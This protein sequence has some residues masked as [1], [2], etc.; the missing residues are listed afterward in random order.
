MLLIAGLWFCG[1]CSA[2]PE[3]GKWKLPNPLASKNEEPE[4]YPTPVKVATTWAPDVMSAPGK[5]STR[6]FGGRLFFYNE[7]SRAIPVD[8]ELMIVGYVDRGIPGAPPLTRRFKFTSE[9]LTNHFSQ[10]DLG[11][12]YSIWVP[13]DAEGGMQSPVTLVP[14]FTPAEGETIK[15]APT[16]VV[17]PGATPAS[18]SEV[19]HGPRRRPITP[20]GNA[21]PP[22]V[23]QTNYGDS[24]SR[25]SDL[26]QPRSGVTT[27]TIP[28]TQ[29]M[30]RPFQR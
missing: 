13:W 19:Q 23:R 1:G 26:A 3:G 17:L 5:T 20:R 9:Q 10:S 22:N 28:M 4:P 14:H 11:A 24:A 30:S 8:G 7:K 12:S 6:G 16:R 15:G 25:R 21:L 18:I 29:R 27:T 2:L